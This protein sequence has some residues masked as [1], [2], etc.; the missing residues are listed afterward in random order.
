[1]AFIVP[2]ERLQQEWNIIW[3]AFARSQ[4]ALATLI[5]LLKGLLCQRLM[6]PNDCM[7]CGSPT[8]SQHEL[9]IETPSA[10]LGGEGVSKR[11]EV[12]IVAQLLPER[13]L[14][15]EELQHAQKVWENMHVPLRACII[16]SPL[17]P[18][19]MP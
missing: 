3:E 14:A 8:Q 19:G 4:R 15:L 12:G 1:M 6:H 13:D 11:K 2:I 16:S 17:P 7:N 5:F 18:Y 10:Y 9:Q